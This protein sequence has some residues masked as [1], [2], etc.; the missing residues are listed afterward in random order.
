M[1]PRAYDPN[2]A[3]AAASTLICYTEDDVRRKI[4][5]AAKAGNA[6]AQR[7]IGVELVISGRLTMTRPFEIIPGCDG[8]RIRSTGT[9]VPLAHLESCFRV[10]AGGVIFDGV[11]TFGATDANY[12]D[13]FVRQV[14]PTDTSLEAPIGTRLFACK[15]IGCVQL[16]TDETAGDGGLAT[17]D[18][19]LHVRP[20][21]PLGE[22]VIFDSQQNRITNCDLRPDVGG[23]DVIRAFPNAE[24]CVMAGNHLNTGKIATAGSLGGNAIWHNTGVLSITRHP[25][26]SQGGNTP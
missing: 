8:M 18:S 12:F 1:S 21:G 6:S 20:N 3:R 2:A 11:T 17:L 25:T 26:D 15:A 7:S 22:A 9:L 16:F 10:S 23:S 19:C 13:C 5:I 4:A 14:L 24:S